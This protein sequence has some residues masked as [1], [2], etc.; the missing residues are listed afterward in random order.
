M[1]TNMA[2]VLRQAKRYVERTVPTSRA[3]ADEVAELVRQ[4]DALL[5]EPAEAAAYERGA[6]AMRE[7]AAR[8]V[9]EFYGFV[10]EHGL[11]G[12]SDI[13]RVALYIGD[14]PIPKEEPVADDVDR[15]YTDAQVANIC[16]EN[17]EVKG[18]LRDAE[19]ERDEARAEVERAYQRGAKAMREAAA[20]TV[21]AML[22][23]P[24]PYVARK[25]RA[26]TLP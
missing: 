11:T 1:Q 20:Q 5:A 23:M 13:R 15:R 2:M 19:L 12:V 8:E 26:L 10:L 21:E 3:Q 18:R 17:T 14:L 7:A 22:A 9:S 6:K 24:E 16:V 4:I 25:I